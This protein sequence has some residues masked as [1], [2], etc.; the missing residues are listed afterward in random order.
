[1]YLEAIGLTLSTIGKLLIAFSALKVHFR[2]FKE[3][4]IDQAVLDDIRKE[5][6]I[7]LGGM[8]CLL[9]GYL[10]ELLVIFGH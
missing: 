3:H 10:L 7:G 9:L 1:M 4:S 6:V 5:W 8:G 2:M